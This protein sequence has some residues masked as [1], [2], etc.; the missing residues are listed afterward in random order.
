MDK[1]GSIPLHV[2]VVCLKNSAEDRGLSDHTTSA[3][4]LSKGD[5]SFWPI[6]FSAPDIAQAKEVIRSLVSNGGNIYAENSK[7]HTPLSLVRDAA[8]QT[9]MVYL[10]RGSLLLFF[11]AVCTADG[12]T[13]NNSFRRVAVNTDLGRCIARFL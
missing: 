9:D 1:H 3:L 10:T 12:P 2:I 6:R 7:G 4:E 11:E 5:W 13:H 8:L